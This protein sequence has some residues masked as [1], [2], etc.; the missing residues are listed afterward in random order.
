[1]E[2]RISALIASGNL[3]AARQELAVVY[4][5]ASRV[6]QPF[7]IHVA[8]HYRLDDRAVRRPAGRGGGD[9]GALVRVG[10]APHRP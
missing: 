1:M 4:E 3:E 2:W 10:P 9:G 8:E 7:I 6:G 5:M